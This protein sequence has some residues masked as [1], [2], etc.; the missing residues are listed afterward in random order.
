MHP[1]RN[2]I[3][4]ILIRVAIVNVIVLLHLCLIPNDHL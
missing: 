1:I 3:V 4:G 2:E